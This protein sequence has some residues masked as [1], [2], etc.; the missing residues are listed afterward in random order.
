MGRNCEPKCLH[1]CQR[2]SCVVI[3]Q[4]SGLS[5]F[6]S[7]QIFGKQKSTRENFKKWLYMH[8]KGKSINPLKYDFC[9]PYFNNYTYEI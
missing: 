8:Q 4:H 3:G 1:A 6:N 9:P 2:G 7:V 5:S